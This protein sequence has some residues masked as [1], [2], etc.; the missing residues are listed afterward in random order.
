MSKLSSWWH[1]WVNGSS[2]SFDN[3]EFLHKYG[4]YFIWGGGIL[5]VLLLLRV[6]FF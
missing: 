2:L 1:D 3:K 5:L 6:M 4:L